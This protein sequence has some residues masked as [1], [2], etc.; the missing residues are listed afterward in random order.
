MIFL[1]PDVTVTEF[2]TFIAFFLQKMLQFEKKC[3]R[4]GGN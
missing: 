4:I 3:D 2:S 1:C